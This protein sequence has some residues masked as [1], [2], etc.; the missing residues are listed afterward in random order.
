MTPSSIITDSPAQRLTID[1]LHI[2]AHISLSDGELGLLP[3]PAFMEAQPFGL[4]THEN[5]IKQVRGSTIVATVEQ[6]QNSLAYRLDQELSARMNPHDR[7]SHIA[8]AKENSLNE[9]LNRLNQAIVDSRFHLTREDLL[10]PSRYYSYEFNLFINDYA[11]E[12]SGDPNFYFR[13]G[14]HTVS[15]P[16]VALVR[17]LPL[18]QV[19][20]LLPRF[21]AKLSAADVRVVHTT[22]NSALIRWYGRRQTDKMPHAVHRRYIRMACRAYQ[23]AYAAVPQIHSGLPPA[24]IVETHCQLDGSDYCEWELTW[25]DPRSF[26]ISNLFRRR[27]T[28]AAQRIGAPASLSEVASEYVLP[29]L[30]SESEIGPR[31]TRLR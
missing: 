11:R 1:D 20:N 6:M 4:D 13:R 24:R 31:T 26:S 30:R 29:A 8:Q 7:A 12:L 17:P 5:L 9:L 2:P 21:T 28:Q 16:I 15:G 27:P 3:L 23:G 14:V 22:S 25:R 19:Y 18:Q 10:D